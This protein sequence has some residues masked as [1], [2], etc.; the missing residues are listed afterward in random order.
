MYTIMKAI[1]HMRGHASCI[2]TCTSHNANNEQ[3]MFKSSLALHNTDT[4]TLCYALTTDANHQ[5]KSLICACV[6]TA[7]YTDVSVLSATSVH[8]SYVVLQFSRLCQT[9]ALWTKDLPVHQKI[10]EV[11]W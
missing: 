4:S 9:A 5:Q 2:S 6:C 1:G 10:S 11:K 7:T 3:K 8:T